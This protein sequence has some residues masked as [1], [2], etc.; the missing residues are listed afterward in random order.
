MIIAVTLE[1]VEAFCAEPSC[2]KY[3]SNAECLKAH[4]QSCHQHITCE[5]CGI[6]QL[7]KN[8]KRHLRT[9]EKV[10]SKD[11][12][13]CSFEG[14]HLTFSTVRNIN[15]I[16]PYFHIFSHL[17]TI[18]LLYKKISVFLYFFVKSEFKSPTACK[19]CSFSTKAICMQHFWLWNEVFFQAC[20]R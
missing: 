1:T 8:I 14:C 5:I 6:K 12:I 20:E 16:K 13:K 17:P 18:A 7:K 2:M 4:L 11:K 15:F 3:F 10:V 9:H 19:S